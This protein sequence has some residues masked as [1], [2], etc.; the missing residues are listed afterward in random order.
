MKR[1]EEDEVREERIINEIIVDAYG[2]EEQ[3]MGWYCYL[4]DRLAFPF[5]ARCVRERRISPLR[6]GEEV[7]VMGMAPEEDCM[8]E[9]L[10]LIRWCDREMGVPL[11]QLEATGRD[12]ERKEAIGDWHYWMGRGYQLS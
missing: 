8:H 10:V 4:E 12:R 9:M 5:K 3:A 6:P 1:I 11:A 7:D 2:P